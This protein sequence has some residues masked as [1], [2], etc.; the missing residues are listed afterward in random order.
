MRRR[1]AAQA[2]EAGRRGASGQPTLAR[3]YPRIAMPRRAPRDD[4][5]DDVEVRVPKR[6]AAGLPA[7]LTSSKRAYDQMGVRR[8]LR[9]LLE[10]NQADGFDCPGCAWPE[11]DERAHAEFCENGVKA[12]AEEATRR[13]VTPE[14]FAAHSVADLAEKSDYLSLIH[15]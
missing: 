10:V 6:T 12:V 11:P 15:I 1:R 8:G 7:V 4:P 13:R 5:P 14:F 2:R 3:L 9:T